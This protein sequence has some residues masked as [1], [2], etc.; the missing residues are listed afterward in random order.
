MAN[1]DPYI[2]LG[3]SKGATDEEIKS[4]Y[5]KLTKQYHPDL[6]PDDPQAAAKMSE[7]NAAYDL[8]KDADSRRKYEDSQNIH[9]G[10]GYGYGSSPYGSYG[11]YGQSGY[12][13]YGGYGNYGQSGYY[14]SS[15]SSY[16]SS[17]SYGSSAEDDDG[18]WVFTPFGAF[19]V[20]GRGSSSGSYGSTSGN[21]SGS[22]YS[23]SSDSYNSGSSGSSGGFNFRLRRRPFSILRWILLFLLINSLFRSCTRMLLW[24]NYYTQANPDTGTQNEQRY[25]M[26][27]TTQSF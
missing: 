6:H 21:T 13:G 18:V 5:R 3:V 14:G 15:Q 9:P 7:V 20:G 25:D 2:V 11:T 1:K 26:P 16:G 17:G 27:G 23:N 24:G 8:I 10:T 19:K 12:S 4:A 22:Y